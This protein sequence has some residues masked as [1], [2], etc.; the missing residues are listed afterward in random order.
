MGGAVNYSWKSRKTHARHGQSGA[1]G[2]SMLMWVRV[3][4]AQ[5]NK[6]ESVGHVAEKRRDHV[7]GKEGSKIE[8]VAHPIDVER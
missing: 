3:R 8:L 7:V 1:L 5:A 2:A 6:G 4:W